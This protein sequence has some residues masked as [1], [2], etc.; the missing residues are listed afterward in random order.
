M[1]SA[2]NKEI[3]PNNVWV[4]DIKPWRGWGGIDRCKICKT[5]GFEVTFEFTYEKDGKE[6]YISEGCSRCTRDLIKQDSDYNSF[7]FWKKSED[8]GKNTY[9]KFKEYGLLDDSFINEY[10]EYKKKKNIK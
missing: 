6:T 3:T 2:I 4:S 8:D 5:N 7:E 1:M 10:E 9:R